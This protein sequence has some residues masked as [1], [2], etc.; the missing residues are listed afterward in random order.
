MALS[1]SRS[2]EIPASRCAETMSLNT[3][4]GSSVRTASASLAR[5]IMRGLGHG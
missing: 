2:P 1:E 3:L 5:V 4:M